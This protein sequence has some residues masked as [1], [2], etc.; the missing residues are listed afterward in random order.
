MRVAP[1][2]LS[3]ASF[4]SAGTSANL[5]SAPHDL[6]GLRD[7]DVY[8]AGKIKTFLEC[9]CGAL[10]FKSYVYKCQLQDGLVCRVALRIAK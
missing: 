3:I 7:F 8:V 6:S 5:I 4:T 1:D 2:S 10:L 9:G